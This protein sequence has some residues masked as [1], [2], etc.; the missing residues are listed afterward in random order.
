MSFLLLKCV[1]FAGVA[2]EQNRAGQDSCLLMAS[3]QAE[4]EE[5]VKS[6][7]RALGSASGGKKGSR[8]SSCRGDLPLSWDLQHFWVRVWLRNPWKTGL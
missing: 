2:G 6:I 5:W 8:D 3:S 7:Q 1:I 4:M